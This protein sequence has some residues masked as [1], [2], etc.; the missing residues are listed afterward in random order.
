MPN[1][2]DE[3]P[4]PQG[5]RLFD[6]VDVPRW[7]CAAYQPDRLLIRVDVPHTARHID[8]SSATAKRFAAAHG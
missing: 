5:S 6:P 7:F 2:P 1:D 3:Q 8:P 4:T